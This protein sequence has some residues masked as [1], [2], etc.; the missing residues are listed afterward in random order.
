MP[1]NTDFSLPAPTSA[2]K[3]IPEFYSKAGRWIGNGNKPKIQNYS[4]NHDVK[5]CMSFLDSFT[6]GYFLETW[7]DIQVNSIDSTTSNLN[8]IVKPDPLVLRDMHVGQ[9][10]PVPAGHTHQPF[11]W[12]GQW[13]IEVPKGYSILITHPFNRFDLPFTT[14]SGIIDADNYQA[15]GNLP[16]FIKSGWEGI[17]PAGTPFA[18]V[19]PFKRDNWKSEIGSKEDTRRLEQQAYDSRRIL[20]GLYKKKHWVRKSFE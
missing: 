10:L 13:G 16:F 7:T 8:W 11:A 17:I 12:I 19:M 4:V 18:Q 9:T 1:P 20:E 6:T 5:M 15:S 2:A 14:M 3:S